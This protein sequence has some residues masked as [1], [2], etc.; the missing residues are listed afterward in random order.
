MRFTSVLDVDRLTLMVIK[1]WFWL[2][3]CAGPGHG[4]EDGAADG[5]ADL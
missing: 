2:V 4:A 1:C 3:V 5:G